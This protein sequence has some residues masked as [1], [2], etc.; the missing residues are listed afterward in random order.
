MIEIRNYGMKRLNTIPKAK[1][2]VIKKVEPNNPIISNPI[3]EKAIAK[4]TNSIKENDTDKMIKI[5][6]E[7][8]L[9]PAYMENKELDSMDIRFLKIRYNKL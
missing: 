6:K 1:N 8:G 9:F 2:K 7:K 3:K 4:S 5:L